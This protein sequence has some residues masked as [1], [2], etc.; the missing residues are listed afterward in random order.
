M[1]YFAGERYQPTA[2]RQAP[3]FPHDKP[4]RIPQGKFDMVESNVRRNGY[5]R[6][7]A[8]D[9]LFDDHEEGESCNG[10]TSIG[11]YHDDVSAITDVIS[12][13]CLTVQHLESNNAKQPSEKPNSIALKEKHNSY[14]GSKITS[15]ITRR[16]NEGQL[17]VFGA[18]RFSWQDTDD[19]EASLDES[20]SECLHPL[21]SARP[22]DSGKTM[23]TA[24]I[25]F[26]TEEGPETSESETKVIGHDASGG[27][28]ASTLRRLQTYGL[29]N[30]SEYIGIPERTIRTEALASDSSD[31]TYIEGSSVG[32]SL[33]KL[34]LTPLAACFSCEPG[35]EAFE[36][37]IIEKNVQQPSK[38]SKKSSPKKK[39]PGK[40]K[41][42][43][44]PHEGLVDPIPS[45]VMISS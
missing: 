5:N 8:Y 38:I 28:A 23:R 31:E 11:T 41:R 26:S 9:S 3:G 29:E 21:G 20:L 10:I 37:D 19:E 13:K 22:P 32:N 18:S 34:M 35:K 43:S 30:F 6:K 4:L 40:V 7:H 27:N 24:T 16:N 42:K 1:S 45:W 2:S 17:H 39:S 33:Q 14:K 25:T 36:D 15:G 12:P 44:D